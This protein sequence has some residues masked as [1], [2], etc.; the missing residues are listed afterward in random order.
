MKGE[1][2]YYEMDGVLRDVKM[3]QT[4]ILFSKKLMFS[5]QK[6]GLVQMGVGEEV[7]MIG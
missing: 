5:R 6:N 2:Q 4:Q 7:G 3:R 1:D